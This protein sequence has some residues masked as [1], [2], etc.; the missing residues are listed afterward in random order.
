[1]Y[2]PEANYVY[3]VICPPEGASWTRRRRWAGRPDH[4]EYRS[5]AYSQLAEIA[6]LEKDVGR[7]L[8]VREAG[9]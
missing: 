2:D 9:P 1:M 6:F 7:A 3:G 8:D 4:M 5:T